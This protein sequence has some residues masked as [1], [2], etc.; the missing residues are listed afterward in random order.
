MGQNRA[1]VQHDLTQN[2]NNFLDTF[3]PCVHYGPIDSH[4]NVYMK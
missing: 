3:V 1:K 2:Q 4:H